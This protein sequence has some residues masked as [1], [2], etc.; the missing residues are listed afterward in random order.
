MRV[1]PQAHFVYRG[2]ARCRTCRTLR[3][4][5]RSLGEGGGVPVGRGCLGGALPPSPHQRPGE[6]GDQGSPVRQTS[7]LEV[8]RSSSQSALSERSGRWNG[9]GWWTCVLASIMV[10]RALLSSTTISEHWARDLLSCPGLLCRL[11]RSEIFPHP[12]SSSPLAA[13]FLV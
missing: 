1:R 3:Q 10:L 9:R 8:D 12:S 6:Y 7:P 11:G 4:H 2:G 13:V 5:C